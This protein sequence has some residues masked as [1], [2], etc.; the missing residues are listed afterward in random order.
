M[1]ADEGY[2]KAK[3]LWKERF[4]NN[5]TIASAWVSKITSGQVIKPNDKEALLQ[6]CDDLT[7]R[8]V[9]LSAMDCLAELSCQ[10]TLMIIISKLPPYLQMRWTKEAGDIRRK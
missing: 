5:F 9:T 10:G 3:Q 4:G 2:T 8:V 6:F 7:N 1:N